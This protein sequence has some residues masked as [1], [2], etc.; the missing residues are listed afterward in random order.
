MDEN[1]YRLTSDFLNCPKSIKILVMHYGG[2][3]NL[4][5]REKNVCIL[6]CGLGVTLSRT[7]PFSVT[8]SL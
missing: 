7:D 1:I 4:N 8:S 6:W 3:Q 2:T 5:V